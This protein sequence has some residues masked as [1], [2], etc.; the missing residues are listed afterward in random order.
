MATV[1]EL[2]EEIKDDIDDSSFADAYIDKLINRAIRATSGEVLLPVLESSGQV[3][4]NGTAY[5]D[6][7]D[8]FGHNLFG[9]STP[10]GPVVVLSTTAQLLKHYPMMLT[11]NLPGSVLHCAVAGT[12]IAIH[13][14]P[15]TVTTITMF[16]HEWPAVLAADEDVGVYIEGE[17]HQE[18]II[19]NYV[20]WRI[21]K[22]LEDGIDGKMFNTLYHEDR[23]HK[24]VKAFGLT[25]KQG[26]SRPSPERVHAWV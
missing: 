6:K 9:A 4:T 13:P 2:R 5:V 10:D 1:A 7:P 25:I 15:P 11:E 20:K 18:D 23:Y 14:V 24:A 12:R 3:N 26:Q 17:H 21:H 19:L 22:K 8:G 16:F